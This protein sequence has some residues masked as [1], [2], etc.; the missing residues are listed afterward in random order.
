MTENA[1]EATESKGH[2]NSISFPPTVPHSKPKTFEFHMASFVGE[3]NEK[4]LSLDEYRRVDVE[5]TPQ[6][7]K[8]VQ[9]QYIKK[10]KNDRSYASRYKKINTK[11][12]ITNYL[13]SIG[14]NNSAKKAVI[15]NPYLAKLLKKENIDTSSFIETCPNVESVSELPSIS[16]PQKNLMSDIPPIKQTQYNKNMNFVSTT[17][18]DQLLGDT[19]HIFLSQIPI[20][21][22][23][24]SHNFTKLNSSD[25]LSHNGKINHQ[26]RQ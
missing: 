1:T 12:S 11:R 6:K 20:H 8:K 16:D 22:K 3:L 26:L 5:D 13:S 21:G 24:H 19:S 15:Q 23:H 10:K 2:V 4:M 25:L 9:I 18:L 7:A 14:K 17:T